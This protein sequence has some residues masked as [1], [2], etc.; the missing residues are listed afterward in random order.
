MHAT[1]TGDKAEA[2]KQEG[3]QT[4]V[5]ELKRNASLRDGPIVLSRRY[6]LKSSRAV[7][8]V[9]ADMED[10]VIFDE[11]EK[12]AAYREHHCREG[13]TGAWQGSSRLLFGVTQVSKRR[14]II[15]S[16]AFLFGQF[17]NFSPESI[18]SYSCRRDWELSGARHQSILTPFCKLRS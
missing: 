5:E 1:D 13:L 8:K 10:N 12:R 3:D 15:T 18:H 17:L 16:W 6:R 2:D 7:G 11:E 4:V 9:T 14:L